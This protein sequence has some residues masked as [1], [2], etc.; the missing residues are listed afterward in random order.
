MEARLWEKGKREG[1]RPLPRRRRAEK[2]NKG[3]GGEC[4]GFD[5]P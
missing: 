2:E 5:T 3:K 4:S 1:G